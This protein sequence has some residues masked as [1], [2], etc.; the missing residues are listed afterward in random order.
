MQINARTS[1]RSSGFYA[2]MTVSRKRRK[3][4]H[5]TNDLDVNQKQNMRTIEMK[6]DSQLVAT[7]QQLTRGL[8]PVS[9]CLFLEDIDSQL[10]YS[11]A[12]IHW[13]KEN[14]SSASSHCWWKSNSVSDDT[15]YWLIFIEAGNTHFRE[16]ERER[17]CLQ[18]I[19]VVSMV[20]SR[21]NFLVRNRFFASDLFC[22]QSTDDDQQEK[23]QPAS[24]HVYSKILL[25]EGADHMNHRS[26][27]I[28]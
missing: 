4:N 8:P 10:D 23:Q 15:F 28:K 12:S 6:L 7:V 18:D 26:R 2:A 17:A 22:P 19:A 5:V 14:R 24:G 1:I 27:I 16:R 3:S 9:L 13:S 11:S 25:D 21:T 20:T